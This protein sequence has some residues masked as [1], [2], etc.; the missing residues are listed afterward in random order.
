MVRESTKNTTA[1]QLNEPEERSHCW[2][3]VK[4]CDCSRFHEEYWALFRVKTVT[5]H[6]GVIAWGWGGYWY[7]IEGF[8]L[9]R[10][11][12]GRCLDWKLVIFLPRMRAA[13][14]Q[15]PATP[16]EGGGCANVCMCVRADAHTCIRHFRKFRECKNRNIQ[17][18]AAESI[19]SYITTPAYHM[20]I[21]RGSAERPA[22]RLRVLSYI[23]GVCEW[24]FGRDWNRSKFAKRRGKMPELPVERGGERRKRGK[25]GNSETKGKNEWKERVDDRATAT[26]AARTVNCSITAVIPS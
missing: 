2:F 23:L 8:S 14:E 16:R 11:I 5:H 9:C 13:P 17:G 7:L 26:Y 24:T 19:I 21:C 1:A 3:E 18:K 15:L 22:R 6:H 10:N 4:I 12:G 25:K 20:T